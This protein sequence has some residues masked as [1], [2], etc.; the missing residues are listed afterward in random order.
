MMHRRILHRI[1]R[2]DCAW[3]GANILEMREQSARRRH[4]RQLAIDQTKRA[5]QPTAWSGGIK[6]EAGMEPH[7]LA[8]APS[9]QCHTGRPLVEIR[10]LSLVEVLD[11][12]PLRLVDQVVVEVGAKPVR[13]G[14]FIARAGGNEELTTALLI[15][16]ERLTKRVVKKGK[17]ALEA[18]ADFRVFALP[19]TPTAKRQKLRKIVFLSKLLQQQIG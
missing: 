10:Q 15:V 7:R 16:A 3:P 8:V 17:P 1:R 2:A 12:E 4:Q 9:R 14:D 13:V 18:A 19:L 5:V 11:A 6:H